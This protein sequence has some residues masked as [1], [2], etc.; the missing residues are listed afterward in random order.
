MSTKKKENSSIDDSPHPIPDSVMKGI[1]ELLDK[2]ET[3]VLGVMGL[4]IGYISVFLVKILNF[5]HMYYGV[6]GIVLTTLLLLLLDKNKNLKVVDWWVRA[7]TVIVICLFITSPQLY[8]AW[9][10]SVA[11]LQVAA[12]ER[13]ER[14][15]AEAYLNQ[16]SPE[17][18]IIN[19][20]GV[21]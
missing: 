21:R 5:T 3:R 20:E 4:C 14:D 17:I 11:E 9:T 19:P 1:E 10:V 12:D 2:H 13:L 15:R 8:F 7:L 16:E 18:T 6:G